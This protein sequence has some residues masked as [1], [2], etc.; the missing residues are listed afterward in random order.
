[1][2]SRFHYPKSKFLSSNEGFRN[3]GLI[4]EN[5]DQRNADKS[6]VM[7]YNPKFDIE[8]RVK[9]ISPTYQSVAK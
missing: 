5:C 7:I 3:S 6:D 4:C 2:G 9:R 8:E 1:M